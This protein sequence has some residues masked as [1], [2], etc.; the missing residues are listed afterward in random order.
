MATM[1]REQMKQMQAHLMHLHF[2]REITRSSIGSAAASSYVNGD[3]DGDDEYADDQ[4]RLQLR[5]LMLMLVCCMGAPKLDELLSA[6]HSDLKV[7]QFDVKKEADKP[8][9]GDPG[10]GPT[11]MLMVGFGP[12]KNGKDIVF[13]GVEHKYPN[14]CCLNA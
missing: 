2:Y 11:N 10:T 7:Y 6:R 1:T 9:I 12:D 14:K 5:C 8:L 13:R 4:Y 3:G